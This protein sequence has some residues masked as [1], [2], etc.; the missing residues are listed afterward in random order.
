MRGPDRNSQVNRSTPPCPVG[1]GGLEWS[2]GGCSNGASHSGL[3][4]FIHGDSGSSRACCAATGASGRLVRHR[5]HRQLHGRIAR[6]RVPLRAWDAAGRVAD[7]RERARE[8][9][10]LCRV[11][12]PTPG[13]SACGRAS[14]AMV[15]RSCTL[16]IACYVSHACRR[17]VR[18]SAST[19]FAPVGASRPTVDVSS[20]VTRA[21]AAAA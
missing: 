2:N 5:P 6:D 21:A 3:A 20:I 4:A 1:G 15:R 18:A 7:R 16:L 17:T 19:P 9:G 8:P 11:S 12:R 10:K 14:V 13:R